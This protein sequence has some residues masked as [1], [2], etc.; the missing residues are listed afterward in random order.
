MCTHSHPHSAADAAA[1]A[2]ADSAADAAAA[3]AAASPWPASSPTGAAATTSSSFLRRTRTQRLL[4]TNEVALHSG[5][6]V[7]AQ[8]KPYDQPSWSVSAL[9]STSQSPSQLHV[10]SSCSH[11]RHARTQLVTHS[12]QNSDAGQ[13]A[14][15]GEDEGRP[16]LTHRQLHAF[17]V[18]RS[19]LRICPRRA[20]SRKHLLR[21]EPRELR[22]AALV[23]V[24]LLNDSP[25]EGWRATKAFYLHRW[26]LCHRLIHRERPSLPHT[27][28]HTHTQNE[29][30]RSVHAHSA[31]PGCGSRLSDAATSMDVVR[32]SW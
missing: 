6:M 17:L 27:H 31:A 4:R 30:L 26:I 10:P 32:A 20:V 11:H 7:A 28:T 25:L 18:L 12:Q 29:S 19:V 21:A 14:R 13:A 2:A 3:A 1:D 22:Q 24:K 5:P 15:R 9:V 8:A 23:L 16:R